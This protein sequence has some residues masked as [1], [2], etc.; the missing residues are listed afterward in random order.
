MIE[1]EYSVLGI[2]PSLAL[3]IQSS[4]IFA[5]FVLQRSEQ[6]A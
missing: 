5:L 2:D 3:V 1:F 6:K 4:I